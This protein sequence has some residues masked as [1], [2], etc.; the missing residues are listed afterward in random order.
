MQ[1]LVY[2]LLLTGGC[3]FSNCHE[4]TE[5]D[6]LIFLHNRW[7][8]EH[9]IEEPHPEHGRAQLRE[10]VAA[11]QAEGF[12][13]ITEQRPAGTQVQAYARHVVGQIDSLMELG[14]DPGRITVVGTSKGGLIAEHVSTYLEEPEIR[15]VFVGAS[16]ANGRRDFPD[17]HFHGHVL[18]INEASD[19]GAVPLRARVEEQAMPVTSF[20]EIQLHTGRGH[21]FLFAP[22]V[23][24]ITP[25]V[26]WAS[27]NHR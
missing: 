24:W 9:R 6:Y 19:E 7:L 5:T 27:G 16:F 17:L 8:E 10:I 2:L 23:E 11:F 26:E 20:R 18:T 3:L 22:M 15:Y 25:A 14:V 12:Q 4:S 1:S 13:V 21:G